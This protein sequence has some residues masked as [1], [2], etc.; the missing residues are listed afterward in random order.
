MSMDN[1]EIAKLFNEVADILEIKNADRFR[2]GAYRRAAQV[3]ASLPQDIKEIYQAGQLESIPSVGAKLA[4]HISDLLTKGKSAELERIKKSM[5][6]ALLQLLKINNLG[7]KKVKFLAKKFKVKSL[8]GLKKLLA[9][10]KLSSA[11]G[12]GAKSE[13]NIREG[14]ELYKKFS[15]RF[16]IGQVDGLVHNILTELK[17]YSEID[18]AEICGSFRRSRETVG[19][20]DFLV[21]AKSPAKA[22]KFFC[23]LPEVAKVLSQG[24][25]KA[26]VLLKRGLEADLRV[27][28]PESFGAAMH[29]FTGS[30]AHNIATRKMGITRGLKINEYGVYKK[31]KNQ[32]KKIGGR[33]EMDIF[34]AID[35]PW[36]PPEIRENL[37][38]IE[39]AANNTLPNLI[40][41]QDIRGD[42]HIHSTWSDGQESILTMAQAARKMG[43]EYLAITDHTATVGITHG[44]NAQAILRQLKE[45]EK[46]RQRVKGII[47][48]SG[49]EVDIRKDGS[50]DL[51]NNILSKLDVV[52]AS[53]HTSFKMS[54]TEMTKRLLRAIKNPQVDIIGHPSAREINHREPI[55]ADWEVIMK[56]AQKSK[57][58]LEINSFWNRLDLN[59]V[60]ARMAKNLGVKLVISTDAHNVSELSNMK[61]GIATARRGWLEAKDVL[62]TLPLNKF[63]KA[64][65]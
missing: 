25:T 19:D 28:K 14:I 13:Q 11:K 32:F 17:K 12:W 65:K 37:G 60:Q 8:A 64:K 46:I 6:P 63:L 53:I 22:I 48:L 4:K 5:P 45:I 44:L 55:E 29:Y 38:E 40:T 43:Y 23:T 35:L 62:N 31:I 56:A 16:P 15:E 7:P 51:P 2:V 21:T 58:A 50:L 42:L 26:N 30:K 10:H 27:V 59:D 61:F 52:I 54:K 34:R 20:L 18:R 36:I 39:A 57:T 49:S 1:I 9:S 3:I 33:E 24:P 41:Q 47:I